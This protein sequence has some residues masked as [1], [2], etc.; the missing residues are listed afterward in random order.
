MTLTL[1]LTITLTL[2][3]TLT[4]TQVTAYDKNDNVIAP[5]WPDMSSHYSNTH[6]VE[7]CLDDKWNDSGFCNS[8]NGDTDPWLVFA[9]VLGL[10]LGSCLGL[11]LG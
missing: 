11:G 5:V 3:L 1:T 10:G 7:K 8:A 9:Y 2:T 4:L 6:S